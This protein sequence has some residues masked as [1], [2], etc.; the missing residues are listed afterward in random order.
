MM[1]I[2]SVV[3]YEEKIAQIG[4]DKLETI[5]SDY[6]RD[7]EIRKRM[8]TDPREAFLESGVEL[9]PVDLRLVANT[10]N[11]FYLIMPSDPNTTL[12]DKALNDAAGGSSAGSASTLGTVGTLACVPTCISSA[13]SGGSAGTAST[14]G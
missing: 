9:P 2:E 6:H 11:T 12:S 13:G 8:D 3:Y 10:S 4:F 5:S 14:A 1:D 7:P